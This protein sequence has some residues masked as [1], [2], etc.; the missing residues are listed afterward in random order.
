MR[1]FARG[2]SKLL[3]SIRYLGTENIPPKDAFPYI[4]AS[5]H[6]AYFDPAWIGGPITQKMSFMAWGEAFEWRVIGP[7]IA[8]LGAFPVFLGG[9]K[10]LASIK[11][12]LRVLKDGAVLVIFPEGE[13]SFGDG[14]MQEFKA[15][16]AGIAIR[17]QVPILP[18][19]IK[20][21]NRVWAQGQ[22]WP[23]FCTPVEIT[24]HPLIYPPPS[25]DN[26][27]EAEL[28]SKLQS[29]IGSAL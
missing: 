23:R 29:V 9:A 25:A 22:K 20:G 1:G 14:K 21:G 16:V 18:V 7:L 17:A 8:Y 5:N 27:A 24:Y 2:V 15:G 6:Q 13:R 19:T 10:A 11:T 12:A 28:C 4:I 26:G 3:W